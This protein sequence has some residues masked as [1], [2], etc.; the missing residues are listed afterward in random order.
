MGLR[1]NVQIHEIV[2]DRDWGLFLFGL[3]CHIKNVYFCL[4][5]FSLSRL[6][7]FLLLDLALLDGP[8][9]FELF[10]PFLLLDHITGQ[11]SQNEWFRF[12]IFLKSLVPT[13]SLSHTLM[14][15]VDIVVD[16]DGQFH[17]ILGRIAVNCSDLMTIY[18]WIVFYAFLI[19]SIISVR[20]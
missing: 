16:S 6:C 4:L 19:A 8:F 2:R 12:S 18:S 1:T 14:Y 13:I 7:L 5:G 20:I 17:D 11:F 15:D 10:F 9:D 3:A